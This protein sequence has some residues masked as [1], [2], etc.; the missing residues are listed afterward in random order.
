MAHVA[1]TADVADH[2]GAFGLH[3]LEECRIDAVVDIE[4]ARPAR[5]EVAGGQ[6]V[7]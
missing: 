1:I 3:H 5:I 2:L 4:A 7:L 6:H